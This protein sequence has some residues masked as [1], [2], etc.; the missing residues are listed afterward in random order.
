MSKTT[1][2]RSTG[3]SLAGG[4]NNG[5]TGGV[6]AL[7]KDV[8][9]GSEQAVAG[10]K[11]YAD[12]QVKPSRSA[13]PLRSGEAIDVGF[14][15]R[16][17]A[18][19]DQQSNDSG[20]DGAAAAP[21]SDNGGGISPLLIV[22]G[23]GAVGGIAALASSGGGSQ[24]SSAP[25]NRAPT[26]TSGTT[27]SVAENAAA[28]TVVYQA[29]ATDPDSG[30]T[31]TY[32]LGGTDAS[33][34]NINASSGAVTLKNSADF[35]A[36]SSYAISVTATDSGSPAQA[37]TQ[38]VAVTV[39]NVNEAP[40]IT[41]AATG[42]VLENAAVSTEVYKVTAT[43]PDAGT[44]LT[45][46][47]SGADAAAFNINSATGSVTLK[48]SADFETKSSYA[49]NVIAT[50]NGNPVL[51]ATKAVT[52]NVTDVL[53]P[54]SLDVG[55]VG[56]PV[57]FN[58]ANGNIQYT[59]DSAKLTEVV[60]TNFS[61]GDTINST[62]ASS[63]YNFTASGSDLVID[64]NNTA[65]GVSNHIVLKNVG[66]NAGFITDE[67]TAE[68]VLGYDFFRPG[69]GS[70]V[71][72]GDGVAGLNGNL[73]DDNDNNPFTVATSPNLDAASGNIAFT[74][75]A[76]IANSVL[77]KNFAAGDTITVSNAAI[78]AYSFTAVGKDVV[79]SYLN[80][81]VTNEIILQGL[82][83]NA[84]TPI[85]TL[86]NVEALLGTGGVGFFKAAATPGGGGFTPATTQSID[87]GSLGAPVTKDAGTASIKFT[88]VF[89]VNTEVIITNFTNDDRISTNAA[90]G[91]YSFTTTAD[92]KG[93]DITYTPSPD[94]TNHIVLSNV[95]V[96]DPFV[97][98]Y[99]DAKLALGFD[100]MTFA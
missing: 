88:D 92:G 22:G 40:S 13:S 4:R 77:I 45:Y 46:S 52:I 32:T 42:S 94:V 53:E 54:T 80:G 21:A 90:S 24:A 9:S 6:N 64:Y 38:N 65:A 16:L 60:I 15:A 25:A 100:F 27:A 33:A 55:A 72:G 39:T 31:L 96:G 26:F 85:S 50:D 8:V 83:T 36:K 68:L 44:T 81:A 35:E 23:L 73:D 28:T 97:G 30:Q 86:A 56:T 37:V 57:Q 87:V 78:S 17:L 74:E 84:T 12:L 71:S 98:S 59:D 5:K 91:Q 10:S 67:L 18:S 93:L 34:F 82:A 58:A 3:K 19:D 14:K 66:A 51:S 63:D 43:D 89:T 49:I 62:G 11:M 95:L 47:L 61:S 69:T 79:I 7:H 41:S 2:S 20:R 70:G 29:V 75:D 1:A 48:A 76:S 99:A